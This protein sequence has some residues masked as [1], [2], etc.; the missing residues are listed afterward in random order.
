MAFGKTVQNS[1]KMHVTYALVNEPGTT[2]I[3]KRWLIVINL[4]IT[5]FCTKNFEYD[6]RPVFLAVNKC[7]N[8]D[9]YRDYFLPPCCTGLVDSEIVFKFLCKW[10]E[11]FVK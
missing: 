10:N 1:T 4:G 3:Y 5:G 8:E 2:R 6:L 7:S 11:K 9:G